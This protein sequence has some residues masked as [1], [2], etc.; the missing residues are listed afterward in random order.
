MFELSENITVTKYKNGKTSPFS[1]PGKIIELF[2]QGATI[3]ALF[4]LDEVPL[5][6]I[7]LKRGDRFIETYYTNRWYNLFEIHDRETDQL[8]GWYCNVCEPA[9]FDDKQ[10]WFIDLALDLLVYPDQS[11][12]ILDED[13]FLALNLPE[14]Q[15]HSALNALEELKSLHFKEWGKNKQGDDFLCSPPC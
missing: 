15:K 7:T 14:G 1:Y 12:L 9:V 3:E 6:G 11:R 8:K 5:H 13:E 2:P 4:N 10:I